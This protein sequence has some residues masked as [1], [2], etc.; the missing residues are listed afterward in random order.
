VLELSFGNGSAGDWKDAV[1]AV[2]V[3]SGLA[4]FVDVSEIYLSGDK[5]APDVA[6]GDSGSIALGYEDDS[7]EPVFT[8]QVESIHY[9]VQGATRITATNGGAQ[10][11]RLRLNQSYEQ[12]KASEIV[13]DL[14]SKAGVDT[15]SIEDGVN[16]PYLV[17]DNRR[18]VYQHIVELARRSG[19]LAF[20]TAAGKLTFAP[21]TGDSPVQTFTYGED[22]LALE[23][24]DAVPVVG[25]VNTTGEGAAGS[26]GQDAWSWV[27]KDPSP[28]QGS[29]GDGSPVREIQ[30]SALRSG[31]AAQSSA[32]GIAAAAGRM[33]LS[34]RLLV[35]GAASVTTGSTIEISG[36]PQDALNGTCMV[37]QVRHHYSKREGFTT[38]VIVSKTGDS[39]TGGLL[40]L[41]KG[42]L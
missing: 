27:V 21:Y 23:L 29:S 32:D 12:Q 11:A 17:I 24:I 8:G 6:V 13:S 39:S 5:P 33:N 10:L 34:G 42:L 26:K 40:G 41:L 28:V 2:T 19:F 7:S 15:G 14:A 35:P 18:R 31:D 9:S 1:I 38:L 22:I 25:A 37:R 16:F 3:E 36:A 30:D 4:P 20:F